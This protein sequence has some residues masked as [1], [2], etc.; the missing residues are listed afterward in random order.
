MGQTKPHIRD[1]TLRK[2]MAAARVV[3]HRCV[4]SAYSVLPNST[5]STR[6]L[7]VAIP[8]ARSSC[9]SC[10]HQLCPIQRYAMFM[11]IPTHG[12]HNR[13]NIKLTSQ[14][15][16]SIAH[17]NNYTARLYSK[18]HEHLRHVLV[19]MSAHVCSSERDNHT[20]TVIESSKPHTLTG[21]T[22]ISELYM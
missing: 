1:Y 17:W 7:F 10:N 18:S 8:T 4:H 12:T 2:L 13:W 5:S 20:D 3:E 14:C 19:D 16:L 21:D 15:V 6:S 9:I 11:F 22:I